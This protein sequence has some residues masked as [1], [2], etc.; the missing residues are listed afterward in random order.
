MPATLT[1]NLERKLAP[2][3]SVSVTDEAQGIVEAFVAVMGNID[4]VD[5]IIHPGAFVKTIR[6]NG[7]KIRVL[8]QHQNDSVKH[9][10]GRAIELKEVGRDALP[11]AIIQ[12]FPDANGALYARMQFNLKTQ[13]GRDVFANIQQG[14]VDEWSIGYVPLD[15]ERGYVKDASG[16]SRSVRHLRTIA[17]REISAVVNGANEATMTISA[18]SADAAKGRTRPALV[19]R[20]PRL[21]DA[22][23]GHLHRAFTIFADDLYIKGAITRDERITLAAA[24]GQALDVVDDGLP[25]ALATKMLHSDAALAYAVKEAADVPLG[26]GTSRY[27][28]AAYDALK[29]L[30][31]ET[32]FLENEIAVGE[33]AQA[34]IEAGVVEADGKPVPE[35]ERPQARGTQKSGPHEPAPDTLRLLD[36]HLDEIKTIT[37]LE[38][39]R[40]Q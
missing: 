10:L 2:M 12:R 20:G 18:K 38:Q 29:T 39:A 40:G 14:H 28:R 26:T 16:R 36:L 21:A 35:E 33:A 27:L 5:D 34:A 7:H 24:I 15:H 3:P 37:L 1:A 13:L 8:D 31:T 32:G 25:R 22:I 17:L 19:M 6:E 9:V 4:L 23:Q 30:L 11:P